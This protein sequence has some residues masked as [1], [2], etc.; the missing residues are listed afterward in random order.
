MKKN[1]QYSSPNK[2]KKTKHNSNPIGKNKTVQVENPDNY[3]KKNA[4][5]KFHRCCLNNPLSIARDDWNIWEH[6]ILPKLIEFQEMTWQELI[7]T[8]KGRGGGSK[9]HNVGLDRLTEKGIKILE[10]SK[11]DCDEVF[12][13]RL[14]GTER[15]IGLLS[16]GVL[17]ILC[18][19]PDHKFV[20][21]KKKHT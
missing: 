17:E 15:I 16:L 5:W 1:V 9:H 12:S 7:N 10:D 2:G 8:P 11:I 18:Y 13:L 14:S 6:K 4:Q 3:Y 20:K 19:D 21:S